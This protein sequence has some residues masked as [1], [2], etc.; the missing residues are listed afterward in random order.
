MV[1]AGKA[2]AAFQE[3]LASGRTPFD[4][5]RDALLRG[6]G[7]A[8]ERYPAA[9]QRGLR[10][11]VGAGRCIACHA[12]PNFSDGEFHRSRIAS[13]LHDGSAD[14]GRA[15]GVAT[16]RASAYAR[17]GRFADGP[18]A[19]RPELPPAARQVPFARRLCERSPSR[20]PTCTTAASPTSAMR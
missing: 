13:K 1:D 2:L 15:H 17:N 16:L 5:F 11:F 10:L 18:S 3:T 20:R 7:A 9:A 8:A 4:D 6:D 12:G 19:P 14:A